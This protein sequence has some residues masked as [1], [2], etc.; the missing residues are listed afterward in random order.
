MTS[1]EESRFLA[2]LVPAPKR[3]EDRRS[4]Q[5][6]SEKSRSKLGRLRAD[7]DVLLPLLRT[8]QRFGK[9]A[10]LWVEAPHHIHAGWVSDARIL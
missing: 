7:A 3:V 4:L 6:R 1:L 8:M 9:D 5:G 2:P 10:M